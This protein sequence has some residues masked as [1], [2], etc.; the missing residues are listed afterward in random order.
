MTDTTSKLICV[1]DRGMRVAQ[2]AV[3]E[4]VVVRLFVR[5]MALGTCMAL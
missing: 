5:R 1:L 2:V 3:R 4:I